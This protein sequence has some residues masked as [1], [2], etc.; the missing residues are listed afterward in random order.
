M[1]PNKARV[2]PE[3]N[4]FL[5][6]SLDSVATSRQRFAVVSRQNVSLGQLLYS[7]HLLNKD[8][9]VRIVHRSMLLK[10]CRFSSYRGFYE[11]LAV[12][13]CGHGPHGHNPETRID[14]V[15][16]FRK[17][18][19]DCVDSVFRGYKGGDFLMTRETP[20]WVAP[21]GSTGH[22]L[23]SYSFARGRL[24]LM[25]SPEDVLPSVY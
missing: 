2:L 9:P 4:P 3:E 18:L 5:R 25:V 17:A 20:L 6:G 16:T 12:V 13:P 19:E 22:P 10:P 15:H 7:T 21:Y 24:L 14:T 1:E 11:D 23:S 8:W